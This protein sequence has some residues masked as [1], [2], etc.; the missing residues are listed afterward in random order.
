M[1]DFHLIMSFHKIN[2]LRFENTIGNR[3]WPAYMF[4][5]MPLVAKN[6]YKG[7]AIAS[8]NLRHAGLMG[9]PL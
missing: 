3:N 4:A 5:P 8:D 2:I 9:R 7:I 1:D 6:R